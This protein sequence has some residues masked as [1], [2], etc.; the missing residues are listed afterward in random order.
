M[1]RRR[2]YTLVAR[3]RAIWTR[4][5]S[6]LAVQ[7]KNARKKK[8]KK[9]NGFSVLSVLKKKFYHEVFI[10]FSFDILCSEM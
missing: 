6:E 8:L 3:E 2:E 5:K 10:V 7:L 9:D 1:K 4:H